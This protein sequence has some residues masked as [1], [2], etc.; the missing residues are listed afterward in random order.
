MTARG[1]DIN[2]AMIQYKPAAKYVAL[3]LSGN[4]IFQY[5]KSQKLRDSKFIENE[6]THEVNKI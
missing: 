6:T 4:P 3:V 2:F 1:T 5:E